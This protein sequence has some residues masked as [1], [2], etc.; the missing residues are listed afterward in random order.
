MALL[1][2]NSYRSLRPR[3]EDL[4]LLPACRKPIAPTCRKP[5]AP[6]PH[7]ENLSIPPPLAGEGQGGGVLPL[8]IRLHFGS[9][10][11]ELWDGFEVTGDR[12]DRG[13]RREIHVE[14]PCVEHLRHKT[15]VRQ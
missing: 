7:A 13:E 4:S 1:L 11:G 14:T 10:S 6:S 12:F 3:A 5:I 9:R 2:R 8:H 15:D